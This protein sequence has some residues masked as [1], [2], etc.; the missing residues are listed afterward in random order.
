MDAAVRMFERDYPE[1]QYKLLA[2]NSG[3]IC[4]TCGRLSRNSNDVRERYCGACHRFHEV[5]P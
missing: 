2:D 4:L 5:T 3:I 1:Q